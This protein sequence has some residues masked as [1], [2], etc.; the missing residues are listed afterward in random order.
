MDPA[1]NGDRLWETAELFNNLAT[2]GDFDFDFGLKNEGN[3]SKPSIFHVFLTFPK[4]I[5]AKL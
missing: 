3:A 5:L 4:L 2:T 1:I